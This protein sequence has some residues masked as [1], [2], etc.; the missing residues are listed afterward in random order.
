[1]QSPALY[2]KPKL[3][4]HFDVNE[5]IMVGD[6]A[7]GDTLED[8][9]NKIVCKNAYVKGSEKSMHLPTHWSISYY[10]CLFHHYHACIFHYLLN[11][12]V[13][14]LLLLCDICVYL[15]HSL[16]HKYAQTHAHSRTIS[17]PSS[18]I[19][20]HRYNG[21]PSSSNNPP[22]LYT[23]WN[24]PEGS[25]AYYRA[26]HVVNPYKKNFTENGAPGMPYR[27]A[28]NDMKTAL[29]WPADSDADPDPRLCH[30]GKHHFLL[31]AFFHTISTLKQQGRSFGVVIR[32]FGSDAIDVVHALNAFAE[33][34]HLS[35]IS[36]VDEMKIDASMNVW[37]GSYSEDGQ[38]RLRRGQ[39][40]L[41]EVEA[42]SLL[43][44]RSQHISCVVCTDDYKWWRAH[45]YHPSA[46][47]PLWI[48][49]DDSTCHHIFFDD[50][51]HALEDDSIVSV[52]VRESANH[53]FRVM[54]GN[55]ILLQ[56]GIHLVR[57]PTIEPILNP[58]W[59]VE[60]IGKCE[61]AYAARQSTSFL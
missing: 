14:E 24:I 53:P 31:P 13:I 49:K 23:D 27:F 41:G 45:G 7:G 28:Y 21:T 44:A 22:P 43:E 9:L 6:P 50:N 2:V 46:G 1:M 56:Q 10:F 3:I 4:L 15:P 40:E 12:G 57:T 29:I 54:S 19:H 38:F 37:H 48:T 5:T 18:H 59:F 8:C 47:K 36:P 33:G 25:V 60:Q 20:F 16:T 42:L 52:R 17:L 34:K 39:D 61:A 30:D 32:T 11:R 35:S 55:E 26:G 58:S 51:I